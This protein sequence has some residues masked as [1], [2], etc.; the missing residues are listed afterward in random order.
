MNNCEIESVRLKLFD[1]QGL[2]AFTHESVHRTTTCLEYDSREGLATILRECKELT[3]AALE[4]LAKSKIEP[5][6]S[7]DEK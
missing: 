3:Q 4:E 5:R 6:R 7:T 1:L 2:L